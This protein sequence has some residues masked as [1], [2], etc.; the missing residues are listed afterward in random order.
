MKYTHTLCAALLAS[1]TVGAPQARPSDLEPDDVTAFHP[2]VRLHAG[3]ADVAVEEPG[4]ASPAWHDVN[5]DG[6]SD[7]VV[8]QFAGGKMRVH[9]VGESGA[10]T[11][12]TWLRAGGKVAE[13]PGV[14]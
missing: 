14:W 3:G 9:L 5:G 11:E 2:P 8:G 7:L 1:A 12:G 6:R 4:Y 10:L 13:V